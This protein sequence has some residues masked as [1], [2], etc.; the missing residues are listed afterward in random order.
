MVKVIAIDQLQQFT[1]VQLL[2][3]PG[4]I[5]GPVQMDNTIVVEL[6]WQLSSGNLAANVLHGSVAAG[7]TPTPAIATQVATQ[8]VALMNSS[9]LTA[10]MAPSTA[11]GIVVLRDVR[12]VNQPF[13]VSTAAS[14]NGTGTG[15]ALPNEVAAVIT[16]RTALT[17]QANRGR[18]YIP[19]FTS[20]SIGTGDVINS[21]T[22]TALSSFA[23]GLP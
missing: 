18:V 17:G 16:L 6:Q 13:I 22:M 15:T 19:G 21:A 1:A 9:G 7:F 20:A 3:D 14:V 12:V 10:E 11:F 4:A 8:W 5:A 2:A 23:A